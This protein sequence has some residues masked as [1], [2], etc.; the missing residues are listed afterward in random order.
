MKHIKT[1]GVWNHPLR[2][3]KELLKYVN[4][5]NLPKN[6]LIIGSADGNLAICAAKYGFQVTAV[7]MDKR[8]IYGCEPVIIDGK[9]KEVIGML[10]RIELEGD[11]DGLITCINDDYMNLSN[12][13]KFS[14]IFTS[15]SIHYPENLKYTA[16][17][18]IGKM[19][20][21]LDDNGILLLEYIHESEESKQYD[22]HYVTKSQVNKILSDRGDNRAIR[23]TLKVYHEHGNIVDPNDHTLSI[24]RVYVQKNG[25]YVEDFES[26]NYYDALPRF[27]KNVYDYLKKIG[28]SN[29]VVADVGSGTGRIAID[30]L[31]NNNT[32]YGIDPD[33]YMR[34]IA[35]NKFGN[36]K[37]FIS[38]DGNDSTMN[39][40]DKSVDFVIA[41]QSFHRFDNLL[42]KKEC[43]RVLRNPNNVIIIWYRVNFNNAI[44]SQ[45]LN[46]F[47]NRYPKYE[48]RYETDEITGSKEEE[49]ANN[50]DVNE[51]FNGKST[52]KSINSTSYLN[53]N[54]FITLGL[55]L[56]LYPVTHKLN[57]A[58]IVL[59]D[60]NFD[61]KGYIFDLKSIF[62]KYSKD[63]KIK[64]EFEVQIHSKK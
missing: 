61:K 17:E 24:A 32:V 2:R 11:I 29:S 49:I 25:K 63:N 46:S 15:N 19:V 4:K 22:G 38:V 16:E 36:N 7:E 39:L 60:E 44:F 18:L 3:F 57:N 45:M 52:M 30:L 62:M 59:H 64:L 20:D 33:E 41:S 12:D 43:N 31:N 21:L 13:K 56:A 14:L 27:S 9:P 37:K 8:L 54:E 55:S 23:H 5:Y 42:F 35:E 51:F 6:I 40:S 47:K 1:T 28:V 58:S 48:S 10:K 26:A 34:K 53:E 50:K